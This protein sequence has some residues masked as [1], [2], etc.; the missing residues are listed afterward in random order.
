MASLVNLKFLTVESVCSCRL[1]RRGDSEEGN[2]AKL[3][4]RNTRCLSFGMLQIGTGATN[5]C[6]FSPNLSDEPAIKVWRFWSLGSDG[7]RAQ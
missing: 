6:S 7:G 2:G 4:L 3:M 1:S 5:L